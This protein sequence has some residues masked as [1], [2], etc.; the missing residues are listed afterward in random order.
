VPAKFRVKIGR[1]AEGDIEEIWSFIAQDSPEKAGQFIARLEEQLTML[2]RF[3]ER[4]S[5]IP[6]NEILGTRYRHLVY[7][8]YRTVFRIAGRTVYVLRIVHGAR[9]LDSSMFED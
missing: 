1:L 8:K 2:E 4:C 6:E 7:G 9:L 3:P 5:L